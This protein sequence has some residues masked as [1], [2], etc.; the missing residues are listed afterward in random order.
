MNGFGCYAMQSGFY[1]SEYLTQELAASRG[2]EFPFGVTPNEKRFTRV[3][4]NPR[5]RRQTNRRALNAI[6]HVALR[7]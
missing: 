4:S 7:A 1:D 5:M 3:R 2:R 6:R